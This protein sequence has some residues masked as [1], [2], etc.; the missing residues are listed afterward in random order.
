MDTTTA[1]VR[2]WVAA[3]A[4]AAP[5]GRRFTVNDDRFAA[6]LAAV[7]AQVPVTIPDKLGA[8]PTRSFTIAFGKLRGFQIASLPSAVPLLGSLKALAESPGSVESA[9]AKVKELSG[10][11]P[12]A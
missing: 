6:E 8:G 7:T 12:L 4:S 11:G 2:F 10:D 5:S 1:R 3:A 9:A